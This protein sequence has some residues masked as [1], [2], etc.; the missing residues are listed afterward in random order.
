M[1][2]GCSAP[3]ALWAALILVVLSAGCSQHQAAVD[4]QPEPP[5]RVVMLPG[6]I[7][8]TAHLDGLAELV[9]E[10]HPQWEIDLRR[11]GPAFL[12]LYNLHAYQRNR[13]TAATRAAELAAYRR[14]NPEATICVV[15]YSGGAAMAVFIVEALPDDVMIDRLLL[16]APAISPDY[17]L[18][19]RVLP[20]V[21]EFVVNCASRLDRQV[22]WGTRV[23]GTM[24]RVKTVSAGHC[25][26]EIEHPKLVQ[27]FWDEAMRREGHFGNHLSYVSRAWQRKH[28]LP[29]LD[30]ELNVQDVRALLGPFLAPTA[31]PSPGD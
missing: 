14:Q 7:N 11:W 1:P 10:A 4:P 21:R 5:G 13:R 27:I 28:L 25:G 22:S 26:F 30:P 3:Q 9:R 6:V 16:V 19:E 18:V 24:D 17:P 23:F 20:H 31:T 29:A 15:G 8:L 12:S 2:A